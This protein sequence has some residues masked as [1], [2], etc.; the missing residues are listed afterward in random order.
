VGGELEV[1]IEV[2]VPTTAL[3]EQ[4]RR[5]VSETV[6]ILDGDEAPPIRVATYA[7]L[8]EFVPGSLV[9]LD[10]AH[11]LGGAW[12]RRVE[13][14]LQGR[15]CRVL[16]LTATPPYGAKAWPGFAALVGTDPVCIE[17]PPLVRDGH[18]C[19]YQDLAWPVLADDDSLARLRETG[20]A[21]DAVDAALGDELERWIAVRLREDL[22]ELTEA[23]FARDSGLL[24]AL[25]R[26]HTRAGGA[27]P[28]DLPNDPEFT[29]AP[30]LQDRARVL[31]D[32]G[33]ERDSVRDAIRAVG[34]RP[35][36]RGLVL[37]EDVS[38]RILADGEAR[39]RG[40]HEVLGLESGRR[41]DWTRALVLVDRDVEGSRLS[42]REVLKSLVSDPVTDRLDPILVTGSVFW[43]DDDVWARVRPRLPELAWT[44]RPGHHE[45]DVSGWP[46]AQR[47]AVATRLLTDGVTKCL[48]GTHHLLGEGW[49]CPAVN[50]VV[51]LTGITA[52]IT[53]NQVRGRGLRRDPADP[54]KV[55]SLWDIV[56]IA[57]G[58]PG[59]ERM[60]ERLALRHEHTLGIDSRGRIRTGVERIDKDLAGT[61]EEVA[62]A[63]PAIR[64]RMIARVR[65]EDRAAELWAVGKDYRDRRS[66]RVD[67]PQLQTVATLGVRHRPEKPL[68]ARSAAWAPRARRRRTARI[69]TA[70][71]GLGTTTGAAIV[72]AVTGT[73]PFIAV[74][75]GVL[76][77]AA[78]VGFRRREAGAQDRR[79]AELA[80]LHAA[81][82]EAGLAKGVLRRDGATAWLEGPPE[83]SK[84]FAE[85]AVE[86]LGRIR[87][88][89]YLLLEADGTVQTIPSVLAADRDLADLFAR[90]WADQVASCEAIFARRGRGRE[91][92]A[93]AWKLSG[94]QDAVLVET[95]E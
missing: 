14:A 2:R 90:H 15:D 89:R 12:G 60:L 40:L 41:S 7:G 94:R 8:G 17:T 84:R 39:L 6:A 67:E 20:G 56:A 73:L 31:W 1:P 95:W 35:A 33:S 48:V 70:M 10:E 74:G 79:G 32:F 46:T 85:A 87:F 72:A 16:G 80:A 93:E 66:W 92:L 69:V 78:E 77:A 83:D 36:G 76:T 50:V 75:A 22:W 30:T 21:L 58:I 42:A 24:V 45:V 4:W 19:P 62:A 27:L 88:P 28:L 29:C 86:L 63:V 11:H 91:L 5:Q 47:V 23:R 25:C 52:A 51:D 3:V 71:V 37:H 55:A 34:F 64:E 49:D 43:I 9:V 81:L 65:A 59:G 61:L 38:H 68:P 44:E 57:P 13:A 53:I 54:A 82:Q 26:V 18:L